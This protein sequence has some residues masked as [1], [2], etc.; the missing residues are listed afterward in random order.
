MI[1]DG[2]YKQSYFEIHLPNIKDFLVILNVTYCTYVHEKITLKCF[3]RKARRRFGLV[4]KKVTG[5]LKRL[6][7]IITL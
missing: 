1:E 4:G 6:N 3:L 5:R 2:N 7:L